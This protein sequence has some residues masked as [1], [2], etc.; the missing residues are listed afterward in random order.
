MSGHTLQGLYS[1]FVLAV[2]VATIMAA[3]IC[4]FQK[5]PNRSVAIN[6]LLIL[7]TLLPILLIGG[8]F[9]PK[10]KKT[11]NPMAF[12]QSEQIDSLV[13]GLNQAT[14]LKYAAE[15]FPAVAALVKAKFMVHAPE[16]TFEADEE[17]LS[18]LIKKDPDKSEEIAVRLAVIGSASGTDHC[19]ELEK[20]DSPF[21]KIMQ[22]VFCNKRDVPA[23]TRDECVDSINTQLPAG[24]YRETA[25]LSAYKHFGDVSKTDSIIAERKL[26]GRSFSY[27]LL[28]NV[29]SYALLCLTGLV[30][31]V[32]ASPSLF[33]TNEQMPWTTDWGI[34]KIWGVC[35]CALYAQAI[36]GLI[37]YGIIYVV[38]KDVSSSANV[39][40][41]D[42]AT[43]AATMV[44]VLV[45]ARQILLKPANLSLIDGLYFRSNQSSLG[46][47][48]RTGFFTYCAAITLVLIVSTLER[49]FMGHS[50]H[51]ENPIAMR[52][53]AIAVDANPIRIG[54]LFLAAG[55]LAPI[56]EEILF[57]GLLYPYLRKRMSMWPAALLSGTLFSLCH[58]DLPMLAQIAILGTLQAIAVER[59]RSLTTSIIMHG[60][61]NSGLFLAL[62][63]LR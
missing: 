54:L 11:N 42:I 15:E 6:L 9:L 59:T 50:L 4:C 43:I 26:Q 37:S 44:T 53:V 10:S 16:A 56:Y 12:K 32:R 23:P 51:T 30:V 34:K 35:L 3:I 48:M 14:E 13:Y 29:V 27:K 2:F 33:S 7:A 28:L 57:R 49:A 18:D 22:C 5:G 55:V 25:L 1:L 47:C 41:V 8:S 46:Q 40:I 21:A 45:A 52:M 19:K 62:I 60:L 38:T 24:W 63:M 61:W 20:Y 36:F 31:I 17:W 58:W 39:I